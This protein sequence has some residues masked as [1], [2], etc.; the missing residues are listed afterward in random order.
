[1]PKRAG[2]VSVADRNC[3]ASA[4]I[5]AGV[6]ARGYLSWTRNYAFTVN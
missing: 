4:A 5:P 1:M 2:A 6:D 3:S